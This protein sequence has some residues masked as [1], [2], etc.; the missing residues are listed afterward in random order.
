MV[1]PQAQQADWRTALPADTAPRTVPVAVPV[2]V[3]ASG[4]EAIRVARKFAA[5]I[6]E[7]TIERDRSGAVPAR[8]LAT[9]DAS[10]LLLNGVLPP[11][12]GQI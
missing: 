4:T 3:I 11:N 2:P 5:S 1:V 7:G 8:E 10:G 12:H 6:A 9:M